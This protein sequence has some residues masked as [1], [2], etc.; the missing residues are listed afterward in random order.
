MKVKKGRKIIGSWAITNHCIHRYR[1]RVKDDPALNREHRTAIDIRRLI[2]LSLNKINNIADL[3][4][5]CDAYIYE[6]QF[7]ARDDKYYLLIPQY[8]P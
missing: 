3:P 1:E 2:R 4:K 8:Q 7:S 5:L 6:T